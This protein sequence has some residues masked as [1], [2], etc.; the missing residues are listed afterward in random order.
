MSRELRIVPPFDVPPALQSVFDEA[1]LHFGD[2]E[3]HW[4]IDLTHPR[5]NGPTAPCGHEHAKAQLHGRHP[6]HAK[7]QASGHPL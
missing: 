4:R 6:A 3:C 2:R 5:A 1:V 7:H